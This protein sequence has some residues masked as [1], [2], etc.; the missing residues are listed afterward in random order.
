MPSC[1]CF[2]SRPA[3]PASRSGTRGVMVALFTAMLSVFSTGD[4][5]AQSG[6]LSGI[7]RDSAGTPLPGTQIGVLGT[8]FAITTGVDGRYRLLGIPAGTYDVRVQR[9]G[10]PVRTFTGTVIRAGEETPL[11]VTLGASA[12]QLGSYVVSASRRVEKITDAPATVTRISAD[13]IRSTVGNSFTAALKNIKGV[14]FFQTGIAAAG[15]NARGFNSAFNNRM[16]QMEDNRIAVLPEN[17]LP[18]GVFTTIP[19]VDIAGVEVLIGPG[20]ALYGPDASNGVVTLLSKDP[21][22]Y[23]GTILEMSVGGNSITGFGD[24]TPGVVSFRNVQGRHAG[25]LFNGRLGYKVTGEIIDA[26]DW[27][28]VNFYAPP[29]AGGQPSPEIGID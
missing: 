14:D 13:E 15:I 28:N 4:L 27:Q 8:R 6:T 1:V 20:A 17:G 22:E 10:S 5:L 26:F 24:E 29:V 18:V 23:Q 3:Q 16:L 2:D 19:K 11:D 7:V 9:I 12:L 25:V 21:K